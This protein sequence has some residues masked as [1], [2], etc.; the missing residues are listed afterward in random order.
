MVKIKNSTKWLKLKKFCVK[1]DLFLRQKVLIFLIIKKSKL[2]KI[3]KQIKIFDFDDKLQQKLFINFS[4]SKTF[5]KQ[6]SNRS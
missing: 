5:C 2:L 4:K 1:V 3:K 6:S